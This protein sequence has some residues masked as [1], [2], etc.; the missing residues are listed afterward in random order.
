MR[1]STRKGGKV[2]GNS[3]RRSPRSGVTATWCVLPA[4]QSVADDEKRVAGQKTSSHPVNRC[5]ER[6]CVKSGPLVASSKGHI[7]GW[8]QKVGLSSHRPLKRHLTCYV[9]T[10]YGVAGRLDVQPPQPPNGVRLCVIGYP[11]DQGFPCRQK[12]IPRLS[13]PRCLKWVTPECPV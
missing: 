7:W 1:G 10:T 11:C 8:G 6:G 2:M 12:G 3:I 13:S 4:G 9:S 5:P